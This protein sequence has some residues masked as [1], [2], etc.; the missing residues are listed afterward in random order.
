MP[1]YV[2][3]HLHTEL[4]LLDSCTNHKLYTDR[5]EPNL[6]GDSIPLCQM[7]KAGANLGKIM[8]HLSDKN[9]K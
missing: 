6:D 7:G 3:Y 8:L 5:R 1:N 9:E 4:S 2:V